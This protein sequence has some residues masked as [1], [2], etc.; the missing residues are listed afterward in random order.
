MATNSA[1]TAVENK[2]PNVSG[3]VKKTDYNT[4]ISEIEKKIADHYH[5][6]YITPPEFNNLAAGVFTARLAQANLVTKADFV[7]KLQS[8]NKKITS[9][10]TEHLLVETELN[11]LE[12]FD[13][14]Y[15]K[16]KHYFD[17]DDTQN[18][19]VFE[20][21]HK[22]IKAFVENNSTFISSWESKGLSNEKIVSTKTSNYDQSPS[23]VYN[24]AR[25]KLKLGRDLLKQNKITYNHRPIVN[26]YL[27][28][29]LIPGTKTLGVTLENCLFG[30]VKLTK[31]ADIDK[32]KYSGYGIGYDSRGNFTHPNGGYSKNVIIFGADLISSTHANNKTK[33]IVVFGKYFI[34]GIGNTTIYAEKMY[35]TNFTVANKKICLSLYY[36]G[37]NSNLFVSG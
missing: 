3:L 16:G 11:K 33:N 5:D 32:C 26:I 1:L 17:G 24:N 19:L 35:S 27:V 14:T 31:N 12:K 15:F 37:D 20:P 18:Y 29:R 13:A 2:K 30:A 7:T 25:I 10:K 6:K 8:L 9:N 36:N 4:K 34:Q 28:Y 21:M 22:Y 23:L